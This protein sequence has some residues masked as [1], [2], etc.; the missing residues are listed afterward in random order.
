MFENP[1]RGRQAR[2]FTTKNVPKILVLKSSSEQIYSRKLPL[3]APDVSY[4]TWIFVH[5]AKY[6]PIVTEKKVE[7]SQA[8]HYN[9]ITHKTAM[10]HTG[11]T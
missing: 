10:D 1:R 3:G 9:I 5:L 11:K 4:E 7:C 6:S 2:N 8:D